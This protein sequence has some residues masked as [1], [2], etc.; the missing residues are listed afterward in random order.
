L[1]IT[2][3]FILTRKIVDAIYNYVQG[4]KFLPCH[5]IKKEKKIIFKYELAAK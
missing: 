2:H 4:K 1:K 3:G 5:L